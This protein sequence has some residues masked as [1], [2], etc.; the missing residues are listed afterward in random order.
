MKIVVIAAV[1]ILAGFA[2]PALAWTLR[3][4]GGG[5]I[6]TQMQQP[7]H[8]RFQ[9]QPQRDFRRPEQPPDR[10]PNRDGRMT[11]EERRGLHR[12]LDRANREIYKG[13]QR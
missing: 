7:R 5:L 13:P 2:Q 10:G 3:D 4:F 9:R 12:D 11:D 1:A 8:D 6:Q